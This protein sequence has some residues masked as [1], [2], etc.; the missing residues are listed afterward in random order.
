QKARRPVR[1]S[2]EIYDIQKTSPEDCLCWRY[3]NTND[4]ETFNTKR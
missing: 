4:A 2:F 1:R 3:K